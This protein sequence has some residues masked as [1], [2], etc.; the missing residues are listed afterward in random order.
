MNV[1]VHGLQ[2]FSV[3]YLSGQCSQRDLEGQWPDPVCSVIVKP[4]SQREKGTR[5]H[6]F[7]EQRP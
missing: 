6:L 3:K 5:K 4:E 1:C 2:V 7:V